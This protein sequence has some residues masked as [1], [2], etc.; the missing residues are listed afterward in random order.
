MKP[1]YGFWI[2]DLVSREP[3]PNL[4]FRTAF[5]LVGNFM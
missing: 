1:L 2:L 3:I 4:Y 5:C